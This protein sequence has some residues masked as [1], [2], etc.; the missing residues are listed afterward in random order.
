MIEAC[1]TAEAEDCHD[2][3]G[4]D[5]WGPGRRGCRW[6]SPARRYGL[7]VRVIDRLAEPS[8]VSKALAVWSGSLEAL[9]AMGAID[10]F[11]AAGE[12]LHALRVGTGGTQ[13]AELP[14]G[15]GVD[16]PYPFALMLPQS[17]TEALLAERLAALGVA[18]ERGAELTGFTQGDDGVDAV[19]RHGDGREETVRAE[20]LA[21]V[22]WGAVGGAAWVGDRVRGRD[23]AGKFP[24]LRRADRGGAGP[25]EHLSVVAPW[26]VGG[27]VPDQGRDVAGVRQA[28]GGRGMRRPPMRRWRTSWSGMAAGADFGRVRLAVV[29]QDQRP[30][31]GGVWR[32]A[33]LP[34]GGMR[35]ISTARRVGR[36]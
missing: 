5:C 20:Y 18:V 30:A 4:A 3:S 7:D 32:G 24:A 9:A 11:L 16:S 31:G 27:A 14:A 2:H 34:A 28:R 36:G 22:R 13:L 10:A 6:R 8:G 35:R 19:V 12:K 17:R 29:L 15:E 33:V 21:G 23:R 26:R 1:I 25:G